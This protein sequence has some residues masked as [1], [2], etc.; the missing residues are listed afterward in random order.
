VT[1]TNGKSTVC[2]FTGQLLQSCGARVFVGG[3]LGTPLSDCALEFVLAGRRGRR[4][5][6][7]YSTWPFDAAVGRS[8]LSV[9]K[10]VLK[11]EGANGFST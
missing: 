7:L 11:L 5:R 10:P 1:G 9:S 2:T 4:A 3:N 6:E 8:S